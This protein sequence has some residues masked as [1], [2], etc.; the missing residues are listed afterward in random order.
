LNF[1]YANR[2][3]KARIPFIIIVSYDK[4]EVFVS[5][6]SELEKHDIEFSISENNLNQR[7]INFEIF[8]VDFNTYEEKFNK[9]IKSIKTGYTYVL[10]LS[11]ET[12]IKIDSKLKEIYDFSQA[13]YRIRFRDKFISYSPETFI[14]ITNNTIETFPMKGTLDGSIPNGDEVLLQSEKELAEHVM[15]VDLLRNDLNTVSK[16]IRVEKFRQV[17]KIQSGEKSLYQMSSKIVGDL[18][19]GWEGQIGTILEKILPAGSITGTPKIKTLDLIDQIEE[20]ERGFFTGV[21]GVFDGEKFDSG[22]M[23][24]FLENK[25]GKLFYK[26]GGGITLDSD[27]K[28]EYEEMLKKIYLW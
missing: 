13:K 19:N 25:N 18:E 20:Y 23:I 26:S 12:E 2:L 10:N 3:G 7:K 17:E 24:R 4:S 27:P 5:P 9:V 15:I 1:E 14:K 11:E 21:F 22:V 16:N 6:I 28:N 8:P